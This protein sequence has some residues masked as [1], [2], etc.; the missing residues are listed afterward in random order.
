METILP[1]NHRETIERLLKNIGLENG[2]KPIKELCP[3][4]ISYGEI[5]LTMTLLGLKQGKK[6]ES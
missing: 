2:T 4:D 5:R 3:P 6:K 1:A